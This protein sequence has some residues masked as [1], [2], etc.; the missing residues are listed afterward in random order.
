MIDELFP[1]FISESDIDLATKNVIET[2]RN[3]MES[4]FVPFLQEKLK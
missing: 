1:E 3:V 2:L 4:N